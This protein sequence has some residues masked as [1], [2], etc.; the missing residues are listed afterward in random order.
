MRNKC[1]LNLIPALSTASC[2]LA[3]PA[4][5]HHVADGKTP[6]SWLEGLLSGIAHP[7]IGVD[8][9][10]FI[11]VIGLV[12]AFLQNGRRIM[13]SFAGA[14]LTGVVLH[15]VKP[16]L[17]MAEVLVAGSVLLA[18]LV[19]ILQRTSSERLWTVIAA[20]AGLLHGYVLGEPIAGAPSGALVSYLVGLALAQGLIMLPVKTFADVMLVE[21]R[22]EALKVQAAG[23]AVTAIGMFFVASAIATA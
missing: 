9:L 20:S 22:A 23:G 15:L 18:G 16:N 8:H 21:D 1:L 19:L 6:T 12:A 11:V 17:P 13:L 7:V 10:A 5:A 4:A 3:T 14:L 2:F